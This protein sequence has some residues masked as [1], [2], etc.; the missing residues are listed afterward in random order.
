MAAAFD[1]A[2][3]TAGRRAFIRLIDIA[4]MLAKL[5]DAQRIVMPSKACLHER[6]SRNTATARGSATW[7]ARACNPGGA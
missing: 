4:A 2:L 3:S 5:Y 6:D 7:C 1:G